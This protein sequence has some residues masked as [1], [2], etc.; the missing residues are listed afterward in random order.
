MAR[1]RL[2]TMQKRIDINVFFEILI[3]DDPTEKTSKSTI[4]YHY[5]YILVVKCYSLAG[6]GILVLGGQ[7]SYEV[8][9][10]SVGRRTGHAV[11]R[12]RD[13]RR[14]VGVARRGRRAA[15]RRC[16]VAARRSH[17]AQAFRLHV[18]RGRHPIVVGAGRVVVIH[19]VL[20][21]HTD[22]RTSALRQTK[23][24]DVSFD[25]HCGKQTKS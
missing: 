11:R 14:R 9:A 10:V 21:L 5:I 13:A 22:P 17:R 15:T 4:L 3:R 18:S 24:V 19:R 16:W 6:V 12:G 2:Q 1:T 20:N 25:V 23:Q 8:A 7:A